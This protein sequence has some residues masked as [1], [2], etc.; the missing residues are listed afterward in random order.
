ML[1]N[2]IEK[3][4]YYLLVGVIN[5]AICFLVMYIG[6]QLGLD[7][8]AYTAVGYVIASLTSFF[9]NS[10]YTFD[11]N[12][13]MV[14]RLVLFSLVSLFNLGL[15]EIIEYCLVETWA[16]NELFAVLCGM[17]GGT[18]SG[19]LLNNFIVYRKEV[20]LVND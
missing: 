8:L 4:A 19:F 5:T 2:L 6:S 17:A 11:V 18:L 16:C 20:E 13:K 14:K 15:V 7:Y 9:S 1:S 12:D 3:F 10:K